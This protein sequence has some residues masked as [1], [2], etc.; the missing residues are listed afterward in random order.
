[1][2]RM[3]TPSTTLPGVKAKHAVIST[4]CRQNRGD[5]GAADEA[6]ARLRAELLTCLANW[7]QEHGAT[8]HLALTV[9]RRGRPGESP[10]GEPC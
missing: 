4:T 5:E 10:E 6:L 8:F 7:P 2:S 9:D 3:E 1:M